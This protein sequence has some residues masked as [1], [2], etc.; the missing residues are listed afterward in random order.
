MEVK[1]AVKLAKSYIADIFM[2]E[3]IS[4]I[5]LEEVE[6]DESDDVWRVTIGFQRS[7]KKSL[8][9]LSP[10]LSELYAT[11]RMTDRWYKILEISAETGR[12]LSMKDREIA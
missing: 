3:N 8:T 5:G 11:P 4:H 1:D 2:D 7:W 6:Y 9:G 10:T 12:V